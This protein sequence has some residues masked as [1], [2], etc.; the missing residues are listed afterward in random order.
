MLNGISKRLLL[1]RVSRWREGRLRVELPDGTSQTVGCADAE[2]PAHLRIL[3][4]RAFR[5]VLTGG[6]IGAGESYMAGEWQSD[7]LPR[8]I[9]GFIRNARWVEIDSPTN[10]WYRMAQ[11]I[12]HWCRP[13]S[14]S[15]GSERNIHEHYDLGNELYQV[16]LDESLAYSCAIFEDDCRTLEEAQLRKYRRICEKL[17]VR[18]SDHLLEIGTGWGGFAIHAATERGCRITTVT[19][20]RRQFELAQ[21]RVAAAGIADRVNVQYCDYRLLS[22]KFDKVASIEMFEAVGR[23]NWSTYFQKCER[24]L[25][26]GGRILIQTIAWPDSDPQLGSRGASWLHKYIFPG[27]VIPTLAE[28][29]A[30]V[31]RSTS[32]ELRHVEDIGSHYAPTLR[33]WRER[34]MQSVE[35]VRRLGFSDRFIRMWDYYLA[36]CESTFSTGIGRDLQLV[37]G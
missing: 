28:I 17:D 25:N 33:S 8:L 4:P 18:G 36:T 30:T 32:L 16:F 37:L 20:S 14:A 29:E 7:D 3:D 22:G 27:S 5:R 15:G 10:W 31:R 2:P 19:I 35:R 12:R 11:M 24:L 21:A 6:A 23:E 34:F 1:S 9:A 13:N 26:P